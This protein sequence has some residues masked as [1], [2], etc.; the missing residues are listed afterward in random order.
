MPSYVC[1]L[2][3]TRCSMRKKWVHLG[4]ATILARMI[5]EAGE[6]LA[7]KFI[8]VSHNGIAADFESAVER[9]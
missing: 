2:R 9:H 3:K 1:V 7:A 5:S 6:I 4:D 8:G